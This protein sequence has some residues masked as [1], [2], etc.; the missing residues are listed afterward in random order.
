MKKDLSKII[1]HIKCRSFSNHDFSSFFK[2]DGLRSI[3]GCPAN[4]DSS[5][6]NW[7][8]FLKFKLICDI[9]SSTY[10]HM[11]ISWNNNSQILLSLAFTFCA[12]N[13]TEDIKRLVQISILLIKPKFLISPVIYKDLGNGNTN[14]L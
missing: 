8:S 7:K 4:H 11:F 1:V 14:Y 9:Q 13:I 6:T 3:T 5:N 10:F 2:I 12:V